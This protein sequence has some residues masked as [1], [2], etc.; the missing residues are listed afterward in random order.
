MANRA[1]YS[2]EIKAIV[3]AKYPLCRTPADRDALAEELGISSRQKLY[4]LASRLLATRPHASG[5][6]EQYNEEDTYDATSDTSRLFLRDDPDTTE[7]TADQDRY[8]REHFGSIEIESIAF[9]L[10]RTET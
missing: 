7:W 6:G 8:L 9:Y 3:K 4:N 2:E 5:I 1:Q 10:N